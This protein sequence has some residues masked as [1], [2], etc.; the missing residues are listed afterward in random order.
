M[1][2]STG[3]SG[4]IDIPGGEILLGLT[5]EEAGRL[6]TVLAQRERDQYE[7]DPLHGFRSEHLLETEWA[8]VDHIIGL[9]AFSCPAHT[10]K[11]APYAIAVNPVTVAEYRAF[12]EATGAPRPASWTVDEAGL[13]GSTH[14]DW[15][16][17]LPVVDVSWEDARAYAE[18]RRLSLPTE[19]QWERAARGPGRW[20]FPWGDEWSTPGARL[21]AEAERVRVNTRPALAS[22]EGV[23]ELVSDLS[24]WVYDR[25]GPYPGADPTACGR[26]R[27][28]RGGWQETRV[29]R[30]GS[31][32]GLAPTAV[33]RRGDDPRQRWPNRTFRCVRNRGQGEA[34]TNE[35]VRPNGGLP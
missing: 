16:G 12:V 13:E 3:Q 21:D 32:E 23:C 1:S 30:G 10:V 27:P 34:R 11:L 5:D 6:A 17:E 33:T 2:A 24:E 18:W 4:W 31:F 29:C 20:L 7:P 35:P 15:S 25:F 9:L 14:A 26:I 19:A 22:P 8:N 28:P